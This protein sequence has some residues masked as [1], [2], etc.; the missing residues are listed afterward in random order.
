VP[1]REDKPGPARDLQQI[2]DEHRREIDRL[3]EDLRRSKA[4]R[5]RLRRE[6]ENL[7]DELDALGRRLT[8]D[9]VRDSTRARP[10]AESIDSD[11]AAANRRVARPRHH[12]DVPTS[13][14]YKDRGQ[15]Q[16]AAIVAL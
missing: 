5:Q 11:D 3:R 6:S 15:R 4:E 8:E 9:G 1:R 13:Q 12:R 2:I 14:I 16:H 7:K 10:R